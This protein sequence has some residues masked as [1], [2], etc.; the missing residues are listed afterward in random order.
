MAREQRFR[1]Y[2]TYLRERYGGKVYRVAVD[3]GFYCPHRMRGGGE[4]CSF[5]DQEGARAAYQRDPEGQGERYS[6]REGGLHPARLASIRRQIEEGTGFLRR[7]YGAERYILYFQAFS[8]T[9]APLPTLR[10]VY[11]YAL[12]CADFRELIVST[13]PDCV[14]P[15]HAG[16]LAEYMEG[17][18]EV[19]V[20]LGLQS[21]HE[22]TLRRI[23]RGHTVARFE[24]AYALLKERGLKVTVHLIF[25]L[26]GEGRREIMETVRYLS[27]FRPD[28][29]KIHNLHVAA[30]TAIAGEYMAGE[31]SVPSSRRHLQY[32][33]EA[34]R[35]LPPD[36]VIQ[37]ITC[38]TRDEKRI[39]PRH[40]IPKGE[41]YSRLDRYL[42]E[43]DIRQGDRLG[44]AAES[45]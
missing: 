28:G 21:A 24:R 3:A 18:R 32:V 12:S 30:G 43:T 26:P 1:R 45:S 42:E 23:R 9:F 34:L 36:T 27:A 41:F 40:L 37:R 4:G 44:V 13:R 2:S 10:G 5:C 19:W 25:G 22:Q 29:V 6:R 35:Y 15:G 31:L 33:A 38:D 8:N 16:L 20:E 14:G 7:R 39:A 17:G 11:D